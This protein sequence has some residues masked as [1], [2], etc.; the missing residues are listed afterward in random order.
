MKIGRLVN[1]RGVSL[2]QLVLCARFEFQSGKYGAWEM[3]PLEPMPCWQGQQAAACILHVF[4][5]HKNNWGSTESTLCLARRADKEACDHCCQL[6]AL[7]RL[8]L[9]TDTGFIFNPQLSP[10]ELCFEGRVQPVVL[11]PVLRLVI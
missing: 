4:K 7:S 3:D 5:E 11:S 1:C 2:S 8:V 10:R 9:K 6:F